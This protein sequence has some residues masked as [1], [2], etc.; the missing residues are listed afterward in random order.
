MIYGMETVAVTKMLERKTSVAAMKM[1]RFLLV[2]TRIDKIK[3]DTIR[4]TFG[5]R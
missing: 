1:L 4:E 3:I 5:V 2:R